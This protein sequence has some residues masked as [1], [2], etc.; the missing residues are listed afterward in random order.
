[1]R[2]S[3]YG[4]RVRLFALA[5]LVALPRI[6]FGAVFV[7]MTIQEL[8][9]TSNAVV[10]GEVVRMD[11]ETDDS[12]ALET[13]ITLHVLTTL[14][15]SPAGS[16]ITLRESGGSLGDVREYAS[17]AAEFEIGEEVLAFLTT[18]A[19]GNLRVNQG[20]LGKF[21][22]SQTSRGL[23]LRRSFGQ[24]IAF[25]ASST[26]VAPQAALSWE[27]LVRALDATTTL[28][29]RAT[30]GVAPTQP[31]VLGGRFFEPDSGIDL[32]FRIQAGGD[33]ILGF[34]PS[35]D[36]VI[37]A[38]EAWTNVDDATVTM[39]YA[40]VIN[41]PGRPC[42]G[43]NKVIFNDPEGII[44][45]PI[46]N[47]DG[48]DPGACR[49]ELAR[50]IQRTSRFETKSFNGVDLERVSCGF[51]I[52]ADN[53]NACDLW[54]P[55]NLAEIATHE[56]G[57]VLGL[58][59]SS[60]NL[61]EA[62]QN[63]RDAAMYFRAHFDGRCADL[64]QYDSDGAHFLYPT[65]LPPTITTASPLPNGL[66]G[67]FYSRDL[68]ATGGTGSFV[69]SIVGGGFP[70]MSIDAAGT[71][72]G[73][74][75]ANGTSFFQV[76][77]LDTNG[78]SHVKVLA[79]TAGTPGP[80]PATLSPTATLSAT[81]TLSP[82]ATASSPPTATSTSTAPPSPTPSSTPTADTSCPGDCDSSETTTVDEILTLVSI[83][84]GTVDGVACLPG[85]LDGSG[86]I[87]VD[88]ILQA[89]NAA[90]S[91]CSAVTGRTP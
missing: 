11:V 49:G 50:G 88:E 33:S 6:A 9:A 14:H 59:H 60:E 8:T 52:F 43:P 26:S 20:V 18:D 21:R 80:A 56:L 70:G 31:R 47:P 73:I 77:A 23:E 25:L 15:G 58:G 32:N 17:G 41:D 90:L 67:M 34:I 22:L 12:G 51:L 38:M 5:C 7:P 86:S 87:T 46:V 75:Q 71:L 66:P 44:A 84:L 85:D 42:P 74:P 76:K 61:N 63:L 24:D 19:D 48:N 29:P 72:S 4:R 65:A 45:P 1:M 40:G 53:W 28:R 55:C 91:G 89:V 79:F 36:A 78:D 16:V 2:C 10:V 54:T 39:R 35:R 57:H 81:A 30:T 82:T 68:A 62:D 13:Q 27:V 37:S 69:W 83:A 3:S 64:R